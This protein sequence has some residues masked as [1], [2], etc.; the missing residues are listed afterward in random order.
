M[1]IYYCTYI[2]II[3]VKQINFMMEQRTYYHYSKQGK[4]EEIYTLSW[5]SPQNYFLQINF[6]KASKAQV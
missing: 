6:N 4:A 1:L 3:S 5:N 2:K